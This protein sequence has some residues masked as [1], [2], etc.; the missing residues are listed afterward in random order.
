MYTVAGASQLDAIRSIYG[1]GVAQDLLPIT[2]EKKDDN[3]V[4]K[5]NG[6]DSDLESPIFSAR[7]FVSSANFNGKKTN[8]T[9]FINGMESHQIVSYRIKI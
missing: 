9:F 5:A 4:E 8:C 6:L 7:G 2:V 3:K 1:S